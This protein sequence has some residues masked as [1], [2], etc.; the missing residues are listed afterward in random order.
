[1]GFSRE[2]QNLL[3]RMERKSPVQLWRFAVK[4]QDIRKSLVRVITSVH[5]HSPDIQTVPL[6]RLI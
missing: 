2:V 6:D 4:R 5:A 1:M 3:D